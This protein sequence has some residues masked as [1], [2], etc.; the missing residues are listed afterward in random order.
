MLDGGALVPSFRKA[1]VHVESIGME[2]ARPHPRAIPRL[3]S[4]LREQRPTVLQAWMYH[5]NLLALISIVG[6]RPRPKLVWSLH[7]AGLDFT[8]LTKV[9]RQTITLGAYL[10]SRPAAVIAN[11]EVTRDYHASL[12]YRPRKWSIIPNGIDVHRFTPDAD[13][14]AS[15]RAELRI[16]A[17]TKLVGLFARWHP[18]KGHRTFFRAAELVAA[19]DEHVHFVLAGQGVTWQ[20]PEVRELL[21]SAP[22]LKGRVHLLGLRHDMPRLNAALCVAVVAS[23]AESFCLSAAE[24]MAT[25]VPCVVT[26]LTFLPTLVGDGGFVVPSGCA[27]PMAHALSRFL[28]LRESERNHLGARARQRIVEHFSLQA[29]TARYDAFYRS[30]ADDDALPGR[31]GSMA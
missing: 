18:M 9:A 23:E 19:K 24:A 28:A 14:Y 7:A 8:Q 21:N 12:G 15:V 10:S 29:M 11:S 31:L 3:R 16:P 25:G 2:R 30:I 4:I 26:N 22:A 13:A 20:N 17:G 6:I 5:A 27:E 1:G